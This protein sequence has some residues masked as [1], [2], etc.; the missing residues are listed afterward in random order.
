MIAVSS[1]NCCRGGLGGVCEDDPHDFDLMC[2]MRNEADLE[3][4]FRGPSARPDGLWK[5]PS[6]KRL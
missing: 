6:E 5:T 2:G 4:I 3:V 1:G